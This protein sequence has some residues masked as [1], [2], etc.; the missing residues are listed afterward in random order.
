MTPMLLARTSPRFR[1]LSAAAGLALLSLA[2]APA[3]ATP[4]TFKRSIQNLTQFP[5]DVALSPVV[6]ANSIQRNLRT[7]DDS[8]AVKIAYPIPGFFWNTM[9]QAGAGVLR[10]VTGVL[11]FV[12]GV[13]LLPF[14]TDMDPLFDPSEENSA[15]VDYETPVYHVKFGVDY[16]TPE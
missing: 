16:T 13:I 10:G 1:L 12:P 14:D 4:A 15:L 8:L 3:A 6:A 9:V 11:E 2:A 7:I 5:L